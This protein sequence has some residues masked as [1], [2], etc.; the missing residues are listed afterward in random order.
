M[1]LLLCVKKE[2]KLFYFL[3]EKY[4]LAHDVLSTQKRPP[5][6]EELFKNAPL[7][8]MKGLASSNERHLQLVQT[9]VENMFPEIDV[10][11]VFGIF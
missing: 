10:D 4:C 9:V 7:L 11:R 1:Y 3:V 8:V 6:Y 5:I 2:V